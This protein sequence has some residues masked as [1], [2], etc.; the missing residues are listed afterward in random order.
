LKGEEELAQVLDQ[1][2]LTVGG[3]VQPVVFEGV[4]GKEILVRVL[5]HPGEQ[6]ALVVA[7]GDGDRRP[8]RARKTVS[9][10]SAVADGPVELVSVGLGTAGADR[11]V[12]V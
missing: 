5:V 2:R 6:G 1:R 3:T 7:A 9:N 10:S 12:I 4:C 8:V 11:R